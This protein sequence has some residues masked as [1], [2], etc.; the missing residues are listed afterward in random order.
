MRRITLLALF[1]P[2]LLGLVLMSHNGWADDI[3]ARMLAR[4]PII[5]QLKAQGLVGE[6]NR[7]FLEFRGGDRPHADVVEAENQDRAMVYSTIAAR[8]NTTPEIVGR[9][10]AAQIA[11][12]EPAGYWI[13]DPDGTWHRK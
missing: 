4:L 7:G 10:R 1:V 9:A 6:N 13:Q 12:N 8:N 2:T 3:K 11:A 5:N